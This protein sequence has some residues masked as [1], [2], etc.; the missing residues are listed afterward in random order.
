MQRKLTGIHAYQC[1]FRMVEQSW[2]DKGC[3][4]YYPFYGMVHIKDP[5]LLIENSSDGRGFLSHY[6][7]CPL[8]D[9]I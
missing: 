6:L 5:L 3:D 7:N 4:V 8:P 2:C 9:A 1:N